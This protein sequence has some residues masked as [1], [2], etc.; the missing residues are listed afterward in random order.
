M[1]RVLASASTNSP[2]QTAF[3][4]RFPPGGGI[5][6]SPG[7]MSSEYSVQAAALF[8][9][10][11]MFSGVPA[12]AQQVCDTQ[13]RP[14]SSPL[15]RFEDHGDGTVTDKESRLMW[16]RCSAGQ[17]LTANTCV[18]AASQLDWQS[19]Q[20]LAVAVNRSGSQFFSDWR[21]PLVRELAFI[22]ERQCQN[23]RVNLAVFPDTLPVLYWSA[24]LQPGSAANGSAYAIGFG[25]IGIELQ[26]M[27][28]RHHVRLVRHAQ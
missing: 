10:L 23:P 1:S 11:S 22:T 6:P 17:K 8:M 3:V 18:G 14:L 2:V 13:S 28:Q 9:L 16:M 20:G 19:A 5:G 27:D 25:A 15:D 24:T 7:G 4:S 12:A 21:L 26:P